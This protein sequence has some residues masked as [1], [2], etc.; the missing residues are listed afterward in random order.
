LIP[1]C[2]CSAFVEMRRSGWRAPS[3]RRSLLAPLLSLTGICAFAGFLWAWTG[4]PFA[5]LRAQR[6]GWGERTDLFA[7][8]HQASSLVREISFSHFNHPTINLNL[9]VGL[10]GVVVLVA[11]IVLLSRARGRVSLPAYLWTLGIAFLAMTSE[12]VPPNPRM[13]ITAFPAVIV[14]A[15]YTDG[16]RFRALAL[17]NGALL[18]LLS[19]LTFVGTTLRP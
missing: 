11:G 19:A 1:V 4:T 15:R 14:Y 17:G 12:F 9:V 6:D 3:A 16:W 8:V 13:L 10:L 7:L 5:T 18:A 2:A